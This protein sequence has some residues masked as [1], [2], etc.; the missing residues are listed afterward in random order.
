[1]LQQRG[2][3][4][5]T[6][7]EWPRQKLFKR[8]SMTSSLIEAQ[9]NTYLLGGSNAYM[10]SRDWLRLGQLYVRD[11]VWVDGTRYFPEGWV[12]FTETPSPTR[13]SYGGHIWLSTTDRGVKYSYFSG[14]RFA[15]TPALPHLPL[16]HILI[17]AT[18][19]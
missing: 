6:N 3:P 13:S 12:D 4:E 15:H 2:E 11:G 16:T 17:L 10:T 1:V 5:L 18:H 9:A 7:F 14:F 19:T 8:L